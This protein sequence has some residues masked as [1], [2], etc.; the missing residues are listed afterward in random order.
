MRPG[1]SKDE[2]P[3]LHA[4]FLCEDVTPDHSYII[5]GLKLT[6]LPHA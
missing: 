5:A 1:K 2:K 4:G 3:A 6:A